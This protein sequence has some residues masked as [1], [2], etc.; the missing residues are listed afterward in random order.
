MRNLRQLDQENKPV[1]KGY[2]FVSFTEHEHALAA[3]RNVN[4]NPTLFNKNKVI[5]LPV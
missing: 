5:S 4:N 3:L 1:S 2:G